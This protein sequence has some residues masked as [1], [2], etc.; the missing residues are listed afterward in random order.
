MTAQGEHNGPGQQAEHDL[1][2]DPEELRVL[3][4]ALDSFRYVGISWHSICDGFELSV[5][6][7]ATV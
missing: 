5:P 2:S 3:H 4:A 1:L 7:T 6:A